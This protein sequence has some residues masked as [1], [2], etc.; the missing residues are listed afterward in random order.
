MYCKKRNK[1]CKYEYKQNAYQ[2]K[3]CVEE[4][5]SSPPITCRDC[6]YS[7]FGCYKRGKNNRRMRPCE[8]FKWS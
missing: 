5:L 8:E 3:C 2:C 6:H 4:V 1:N 7:M